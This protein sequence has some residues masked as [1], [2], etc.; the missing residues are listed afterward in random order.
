[1]TTAVT[2]P[3]TDPFAVEIK[4]VTHDL[5][6]VVAPCDTS[7]GCATTCRSSCASRG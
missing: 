1:M 7:D 3:A 5:P 6:D 4:I 2:E